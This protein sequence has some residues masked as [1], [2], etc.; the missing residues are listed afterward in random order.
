MSGKKKEKK[1][2]P[3]IA[4]ELSD[5]IVYCRPVSFN[6]E[7][8]EFKNWMVPLGFFVFQLCFHH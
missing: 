4:K 6:E 3:K 1:K 7:G 2:F 5:M 8:R